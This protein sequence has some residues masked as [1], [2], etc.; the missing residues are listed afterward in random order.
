[1]QARQGSVEGQDRR[2]RGYS[3]TSAPTVANGVLMTGMT[4]G[5]YGV[6]GFVDG[7]DPDR[8]STCGRRHTT[9]VPEKK[10]SETWPAGDAYLRGGGS[11]W[12]TGSYDPELDLTYWGTSNGGPWTATARPGDNLW[13]S[14]VHRVQT[15]D[16]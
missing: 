4:G 3:I 12:I 9:A 16:R 6:R 13:I 5:E 7:Y 14:S 10:G 2:W 11:T 8:A 15:E 1:M